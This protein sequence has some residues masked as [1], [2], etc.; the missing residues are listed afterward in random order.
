M[1]H[2]WERATFC[3]WLAGKKLRNVRRLTNEGKTKTCDATA[4]SSKLEP[5]TVLPGKLLNHAWS[6]IIFI[7]MYNN[8]MYMY[9]VFNPH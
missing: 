9:C 2:S 8:I 5:I 1:V 6:Y 3:H 4:T 7:A